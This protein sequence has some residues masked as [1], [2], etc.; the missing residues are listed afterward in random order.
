[1]KPVPGPYGVALVAAPVLLLA[2]TTAF[3]TAGEEVNHGVV[4][5][6]IGVWSSF[7]WVVGYVGLAR[8]FEHVVPK[9]S[10]A[11]AVLAVVGLMTGYGYNIEAIHLEHLGADVWSEPFDQPIGYLAFDPWGL[12]FPLAIVLTSFL[13]WR[14][15]LY[16]RWTAAPL[17]V[18]GLLFVPSREAGVAA[19]AVAADLFLFVGLVPIALAMLRRA[20]TAS[21]VTTADATVVRA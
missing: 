12:C 14:T 8:T 6:T 15:R 17:L 11:L 20:A 9:S 5:G 19:L 2:S 7:C 10:V 16:S 18:G 3:L 1:M 21:T 13:V 4:G